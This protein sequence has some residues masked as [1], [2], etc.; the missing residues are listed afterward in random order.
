M[1][2]LSGQTEYRLPWPISWESSA[3][4][5]FYTV[6]VMEYGDVNVTLDKSGS[7][8]DF[9]WGSRNIQ[10]NLIALL[11]F[12]VLFGLRFLVSCLIHIQI[13][14]QVYCC[15]NMSKQI[16]THIYIYICIFGYTDI[17]MVN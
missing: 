10:G 16:H 17:N 8:I 5:K 12:F 6:Y 4:S 13:Q 3:Q 1:P 9:Q 11:C 7:S 2:P 14:N 15:I